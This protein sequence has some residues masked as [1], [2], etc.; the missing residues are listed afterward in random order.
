VECFLGVLIVDAGKKVNILVPRY[1]ILGRALD[2]V[3]AAW[4]CGISLSN[5]INNR[6]QL[7]GVCFENG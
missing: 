4:W 7:N 5:F 2:W 1:V 6:G 3:D